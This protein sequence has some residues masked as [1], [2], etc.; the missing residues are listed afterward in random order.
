MN[1][2]KMRE[3]AFMLLYE[4]EIQKEFSEENIEIFLENNEIVDKDAK[5]YIRKIVKG[6]KENEEELEKKIAEKLK[7]KWK[8]ERISKINIALLKLSIY[9]MLYAN[10]PYK[11]AINEIIELAKTYG[12]DNSSSF[13][14][15]VLANVVKENL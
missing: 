9:E 8:L 2:S 10:V 5:K 12:E 13:I 7:P 3:Y 15:G 1:I 11:I 14:N 6:V 4:L